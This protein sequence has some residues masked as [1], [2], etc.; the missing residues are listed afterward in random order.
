MLKFAVLFMN[1]GPLDTLLSL[2]LGIQQPTMF[3]QANLT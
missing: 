2:L 1:S 3:Y